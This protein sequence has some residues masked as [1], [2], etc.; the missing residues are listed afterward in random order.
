MNLAKRNYF[1]GLIT[2]GFLGALLGS[3]LNSRRES[4]RRLLGHSRQFGDHARRVL[5]GISRGVLEMMRR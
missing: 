1:N 4:D 5:R 3:V 2:G